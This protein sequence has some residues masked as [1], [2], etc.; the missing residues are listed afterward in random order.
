M[1][2]GTLTITGGRTTGGGAVAQPARAMQ[3]ISLTTKVTEHLFG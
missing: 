1:Y 2:S 3:A